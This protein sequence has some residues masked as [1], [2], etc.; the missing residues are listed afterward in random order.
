MPCVLN[1]KI[2]IV[3][4]P[5]CAIDEYAINFFISSCMSATNEVYIIAIILKVK[6][7]GVKYSEAKGNIPTENLRNPY[8]PIFKRIAARTTEP[9]VGASTCASGNQV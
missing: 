5:I 6:I 9:G 8:P 2:P 1:V 3:T 7:N 4:K